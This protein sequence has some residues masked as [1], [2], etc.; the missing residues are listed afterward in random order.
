ML[1]HPKLHLSVYRSENVLSWRDKS[2]CFFGMASSSDDTSDYGITGEHEE[3]F[4]QIP[5]FREWCRVMCHGAP[6][7][8][9][10]LLHTL[11]SCRNSVPPLA[12]EILDAIVDE[13]NAAAS[14]DMVGN[15]LA[16]DEYDESFEEPELFGGGRH[17][18]SEC[19][20]RRVV[21][22]REIA[23]DPTNFT[24]DPL[25]LG[26]VCDL[27]EGL[28]AESESSTA[29][30]AAKLVHFWLAADQLSG[31]SEERRQGLNGWEACSVNT[32]GYSPTSPRE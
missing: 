8:H 24:V 30:R 32:T 18:V 12:A 17:G 23:D 22:F 26:C 2:Q 16:S 3:Q 1:R 9:T 13:E 14:M 31:M 29:D 11:K 21:E 15:I 6:E 19:M 28:D 25:V 5:E 7:D 20:W 27:I 4:S 10:S